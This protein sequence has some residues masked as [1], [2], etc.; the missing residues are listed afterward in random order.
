MNLRWNKKKQS[1]VC[2]YNSSFLSLKQKWE[3]KEERIK[4]L[5]S[6]VAVFDSTKLY[7]QEL[8]LFNLIVI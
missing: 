1:L 2:N 3:R 5:C 8:S 6:K 4:R 7:K